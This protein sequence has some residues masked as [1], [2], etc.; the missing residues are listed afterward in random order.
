M[1][2]LL[3]AA[4]VSTNAIG[5]A[6]STSAQMIVGHR[7]ASADAPEN[8]LAAFRLAFEQGADAV[9]GDC[10][11]TLDQRIVFTH[12]RD[13][14]RVSSQ[15]LTI[16]E[17][18]FHRLRELDVGS[19]KDPRFSAERMPTLAEVCEIIPSGKVFLIEVKCGP[20]IIPHLK[21]VLS[22]TDLDNEQFRIISFN[23]D[24][25]KEVKLALPDIE[26]YWLCRFRKDKTHGHWYPTTETI[27]ATARAINA[28]GVDVQANMKLVNEAFVTACRD[29][30]LSLHA[31]TVDDPEVAMQLRELG[32]DSITTNRPGFLRRA[33]AVPVE[34]ATQALEPVGL[35]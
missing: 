30:G 34:S 3:Y 14:E 2:L 24:V 5:L 6:A 31:W 7:G 11:L 35:P 23:R 28:D 1:R 26:C 32:F 12:D 15:K 17:T 18:S 13:T 21:K 8:T 10:H 29:A 9:E 4:I 33:L 27:V 16:V 25:V 19:W 22:A 20:E